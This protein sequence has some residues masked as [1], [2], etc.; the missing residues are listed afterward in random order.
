MLNEKRCCLNSVAESN[1]V[2]KRLFQLS[3][4]LSLVSH[5]LMHRNTI[6]KVEG[7]Y[8]DE[9]FLLLELHIRVSLQISSF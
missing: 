7:N 8:L 4:S 9:T 6:L 3:F 1:I 2:L 5:S